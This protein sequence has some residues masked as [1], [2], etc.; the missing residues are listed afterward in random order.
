MEL[1]DLLRLTIE[2]LGRLQIPYL[3]CGSVASGGYGEPRMTRDIDIVIDLRFGKVAELCE[4]FP[5]PEF[6]V[7][8]DAAI[9]AIRTEKQ[10]NVVHLPTANKIDFMISR[11]CVW[12]RLQLERR[13]RVTLFGNVEGFAA[14]PED[15]ILSKMLYYHEGGSEKHLR[16]ITGILSI[17]AEKI[18]REYISQWATR[19]KVAEVWSAVLRRLEKE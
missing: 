11:D 18:D 3:V 2:T 16:D 17:Q 5:E 6:F 12:S 9:E 8:K 7:S 19:L 10:F 1:P 14:S 13:Q 15:V 4:A